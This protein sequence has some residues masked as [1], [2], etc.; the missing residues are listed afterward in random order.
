M[1]IQNLEVKVKKIKIKTKEDSSLCF[2][3]RLG[4]VLSILSTPV[5]NKSGEVLELNIDL[6]IG[7]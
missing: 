1:N 7:C 4:R 3:L 6:I 5:P 2:S